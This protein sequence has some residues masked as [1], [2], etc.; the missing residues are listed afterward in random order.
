MTALLTVSA[1]A[2]VNFNLFVTGR[3]P[4]GYHLLDSV[5]FFAGLSDKITLDFSRSDGLEC[6]GDFAETLNDKDNLAGRALAAY[7][8]KTGWPEQVF[9][10]LEKSIPIGGGLG[11]GSSDAAAILRGLN[12]LCPT[13]LDADGLDADGLAA[14]ALTLGADV[15]I[16]LHSILG[17]GGFFRIEG[18]GEI[19]TP[20][21]ILN[22]E[23]GNFGVLLVNPKVAVSTQDVFA[24]LKH[25]PLSSAH[26]GNRDLGNRNSGIASLSDLPTGNDLTTHAMAEQP[27]IGSCLDILSVLNKNHGGLTFGMSGSGGS[28]FALFA[29]VEAAKTAA[30]D[31][32]QTAAYNE[33][34]FWHWYGGIF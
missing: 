27:L 5:V 32:S 29:D 8:Q 19:I 4:D 15:P 33:L 31:L 9:I 17:A 23:G 28:C 3:R 22:L 7:R 34:G 26:S 1:P 16:C 24:R 18:I 2:K 12:R 11:G 10:T 21:N 30:A 20:L 13:P 14:L 25:V 6:H